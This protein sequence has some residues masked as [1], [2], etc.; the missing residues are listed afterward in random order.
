MLAPQP[1]LWPLPPLATRNPPTHPERQ[2]TKDRQTFYAGASIVRVQL[3]RELKSDYQRFL[4]ERNRGDRDS[5]GGR[6]ASTMRSQPGHEN[7]IALLRRAGAFPRRAHRIPGPGWGCRPPGYRSD[8]R[9][10]PGRAWCRDQPFR[11]LH[12][13]WR[14]W[15]PRRSVRRPAHGRRLPMSLPPAPETRCMRQHVRSRRGTFTCVGRRGQ[16]DTG[17]DRRGGLDRRGF[18]GQPG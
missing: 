18:A 14:R 9:A 6:I 2:L 4:Q 7:T 15:Q 8:D 17:A 1:R 12:S 10:L 5:E 3:D 11:I 13:H 16:A